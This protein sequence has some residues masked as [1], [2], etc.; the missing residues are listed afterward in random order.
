MDSSDPEYGLPITEDANLPAMAELS[1]IMNNNLFK[2]SDSGT[3]KNATRG[4]SRNGFKDLSSP[5][6]T[7]KATNLLEQSIQ[8]QERRHQWIGSFGKIEA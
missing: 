7:T 4:S 1:K 3:E 5:S 2:T 8:S 6:K